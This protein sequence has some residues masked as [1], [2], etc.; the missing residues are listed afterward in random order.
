MGI[1][2]AKTKGNARKL[3][4]NGEMPLLDFNVST[5]R[6]LLYA[7]LFTALVCV[8]SG[9]AVGYICS[10]YMGPE[11]IFNAEVYRVPAFNPIGTYIIV[12]EDSDGSPDSWGINL[13][14]GANREHYVSGTVAL[15]DDTHAPVLRLEVEDTIGLMN[16]T[17]TKI[18]EQISRPA[19]LILVL[20]DDIP[21][22]RKTYIDFDAD[23]IIDFE[24]DVGCDSMGRIRMGSRW[25]HASEVSFRVPD[26]P[27][28]IITIGEGM[29]VKVHFRDGSWKALGTGGK[30]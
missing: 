11:R 6:V 18:P 9:T 28:A 2:T 8:V 22:R 19:R 10:R 16:I 27:E 25:V 5:N 20:H 26:L 30:F 17:L 24:S 21:E 4:R 15:A 23:G 3:T 1:L 29:R 12:D 13:A 14:L 7:I